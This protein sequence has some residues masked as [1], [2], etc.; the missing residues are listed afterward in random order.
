VT[1]G[2]GLLGSGYMGRTY[3][4]CLTRHVTDGRLVAVTC[5]TRASALAAE[6][7]C[8]TEASVD[9]I[10]RRDD[11]DAVI[12]ATPQSVHEEQCVAA[13]AAGKHV[14][15][16][17]PMART[18]AECDRMALACAAASVRLA[19]NKVLR[20]REAP[21]AARELVRSGRIGEVRMI[22]ARDVYPGFI[23]AEKKWAA[24]ADQGPPYLDWGV[25]CHDLMRW[26]VDDD[27]VSAFALFN[28][29]T[30]QP[31]S[32]QSAMVQF[33]FRRGAMAQVWMSYEVPPPGLAPPDWFLVVGSE[34]IVDCDTYGAVKLGQGERWE[35]YAQQ[36]AF[37]PLGDY[38]HPARLKGFAAQL[39]DFIDSVQN[40]RE[41]AVGAKDGRAAVEMAEAAERSARTGRAV[42]I[43]LS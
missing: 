26:L 13:A 8:D 18:V 31:P 5:G 14:Y 10:L 41:P 38:L 11:V 24:G 4:A 29:F 1:V 19:V 40:S 3:A 28:S 9:T 23:I 22:V 30:R 20:Y 27:P 37:D 6:F 32:D 2:F 43:P 35:L 34:G 39:Q 15:T 36:P 17:K 16:E 33:S 12:I 21:L 7:H 25:H 42:A